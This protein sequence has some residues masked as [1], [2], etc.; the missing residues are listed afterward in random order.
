MAE[1]I[2]DYVR[3]GR[4]PKKEVRMFR[5]VC[6]RSCLLVAALV[7]AAMALFAQAGIQCSSCDSGS[8]LRLS[9]AMLRDRITQHSFPRLSSSA[10]LPHDPIGFQVS[11]DQD[12][13]PCGILAMEWPGPKEIAQ[14][15]TN[16]LRLWKFSPVL[17]N[18]K[19]ACFRS[20][21]FVSAKNEQNSIRFSFAEPPARK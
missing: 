11:V 8:T 17:L 18:G 10:E 6:R 9:P 16:A 5:N 4:T 15:L 20:T 14:A 12:G 7:F 3:S 1:C 13:V 19:P 2:D 21:L